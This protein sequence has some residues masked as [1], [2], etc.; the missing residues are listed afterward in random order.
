LKAFWTRFL[1]NRQA[2]LRKQNN[3][4]FTSQYERWNDPPENVERTP[5]ISGAPTVGAWLHRSQGG[6]IEPY[7]QYQTLQQSETRVE[8][9]KK[10]FFSYSIAR[11]CP[12]MLACSFLVFTTLLGKEV[13]DI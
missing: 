5:V 6:L 8:N 11:T 7:R 12:M 1:I 9:S 13:V 2:Q 3:G 4:S 10:I